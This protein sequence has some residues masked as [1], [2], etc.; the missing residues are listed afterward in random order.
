MTER[1]TAASARRPDPIRRVAWLAALL[2]AGCGGGGGPIDATAPLDPQ[3][4]TVSGAVVKAPVAGARVCASW[5]ADGVADPATTACVTSAA[6]GTYAVPMPRR[7]ALLL[8]EATG[9]D[10]V[11]EADPAARVA[12]ARLRSLVP[13][14]D[15]PQ[16]GRTV[17]VSA[18]TEL[19]VRRA[20]A[21]GA[22]AA[23]TVAAA[24]AEVERTFGVSG[25]HR[26]RPLD[27]TARVDTQ[28][29]PA[30]L[31]GLANAG[32]RG[33]MAERGLP[34]GA[35]D[36]ALAELSTRLGAG[37]LHEQL[38]SFRAGMRRVIHANPVSGLGSMASAWSSV[39]AL[40]FGEPPPV[41]SRPLLVEQPGTLRF[42]V[43]WELTDLLGGP[44][45]P[46]CI[47]NVPA[48]ASEAQVRAAAQLA[49]D[50]YGQRVTGLAPVARCIGGGQ[51]VT[52]DFAAPGS[53]VWGDGG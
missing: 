37:T 40:D 46:M 8:V 49:S 45:A 31:Y 41:P 19:A 23:D 20:Q 32:V 48:T 26:I 24:T 9:G 35:L 3:P 21:R 47:T 13:V 39:V 17:Q 53:P 51:S 28:N 12:L 4:I 34:G 52:V 27:L 43:R 33:W 6:D 15:A 11:D 50:V 36:D 25:L 7:T 10:Y 22:F 14:D 5:L 44:V 1:P 29:T 38:A 2:L 30:L 16:S 18:L 42:A